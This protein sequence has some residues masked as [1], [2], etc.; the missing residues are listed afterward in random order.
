A[1]VNVPDA[2][3]LHLTTA[4]T[5]EAWVEPTA[6]AN[7]WQDLIYKGNDNYYLESSSTYGNAPVA[8]GIVNSAHLEAYGSS[9]LPTNTWSFLTATYDGTTMRLYI[10]G[11]QV[12]SKAGSGSLRTSTNQLQFGG[13]SFYGQYFQGLIDNVRIYNLALTASEIQA[14]MATPVAAGTPPPTAP[15]SL[16]AT[17]SGSTI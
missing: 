5:S 11:V 16:A 4:M 14:D 17:A 2:A 1:V 15:A 13:D 10:N 8:G 6:A 12:A 7:G 3:A 9:A